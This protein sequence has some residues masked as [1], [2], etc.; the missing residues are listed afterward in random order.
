MSAY[1]AREPLS[2]VGSMATTATLAGGAGSVSG[3]SVRERDAGPTGPAPRAV[4]TGDV[5]D[6]RAVIRGRADRPTRMYVEVAPGEEFDD[7]R[8]IRGRTIREL[9]LA[10]VQGVSVDRHR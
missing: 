2:S 8:T 6:D 7:V 9:V 3:G 4:Q 5:V 1:V 10:R